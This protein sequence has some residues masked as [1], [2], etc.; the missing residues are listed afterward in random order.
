MKYLPKNIQKLKDNEL[1]ER[2]FPKKALAQIKEEIA[3]D[4][5]PKPRKTN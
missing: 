2:L 5:K 1:A 3:K 4:R